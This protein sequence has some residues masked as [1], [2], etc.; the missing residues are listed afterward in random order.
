MSYLPGPPNDYIDYNSY[1]YK[2][3]VNLL[4][5]VIASMVAVTTVSTTYTA[6]AAD[7]YIRA[8]GT[9]AGFTVTLPSATDNVGRKICI[10]K[11]D[12]SGHTITI[13]V[14]GSDTIEGSATKTLS[15]QWAKYTVISNGIDG[16][17]IV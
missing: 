16:W 14:T 15:T 2:R 1:S 3:W 9:S 17:E 8:D 7:G 5:N 12:S 4:Y 13:G 11:I 10:K 6:K